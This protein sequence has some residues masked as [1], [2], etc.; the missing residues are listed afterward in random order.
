[1]GNS[2]TQS[3]A[4]GGFGPA[5]NMPTGFNVGGFGNTAGVQQFQQPNVSNLVGT[6]GAI[7]GNNAPLSGGANITDLVRQVGQIRGVGAG[8]PSY[9]NYGGMPMW[10]RGLLGGGGYGS[11]AG[12]SNMG[13]RGK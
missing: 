7:M 8:Q 10:L 4:T 1:M 6:T 5:V 13:A 9:S 2:P 3:Q 12:P 11:Q